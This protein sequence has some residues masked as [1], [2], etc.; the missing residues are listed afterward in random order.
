MS[1]ERPTRMTP[2]SKSRAASSAPSTSLVGA[3]SPPIASTAILIISVR[4]SIADCGLLFFL[5]FDG[6]APAVEATLRADAVR[7]ARLA[8]VRA[9][10]RIGWDQVIVRAALAGA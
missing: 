1:S 2:T 5:H 10:A 3:K 9:G 7:Q 8:A 6:D 4:Q